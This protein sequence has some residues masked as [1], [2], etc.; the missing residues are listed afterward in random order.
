MCTFTHAH[1][2]RM[3][4][5][6][7]FSTA[8]IISWTHLKVTLYTHCLLFK[9]RFKQFCQLLCYIVLLIHA[10]MSME[11]SRNDTER[12]E[13]EYLKKYLS[14]CHSVHH[15]WQTDWSGTEPEPIL[16]EAGDQP[17]EPLHDHY[18]SYHGF[19]GLWHHATWQ[20]ATYIPEVMWC[21]HLPDRT[22]NHNSL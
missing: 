1:T 22:G 13:P 7:G 15:K 10:W 3:C 18:T 19:S 5:T 20:V 12:A 11:Y 17:P 9:D 16:W 14:Q 6:Y 8:T 21:L 2:C 4:N